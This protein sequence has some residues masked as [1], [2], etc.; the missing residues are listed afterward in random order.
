MNVRSGDRRLPS[1]SI[2]I[3]L[4]TSVMVVISA[5]GSWPAELAQAVIEPPF[6]EN[7]VMLWNFAE[8]SQACLPYEDPLWLCAARQPAPAQHDGEEIQ[9][10]CRPLE[11]VKLSGPEALA[12]IA[13]DWER[14]D[15]LMRPRTP[16]SSVLWNSLWWKHYHKRGLLLADEFL[17][18]AVRATNGQL[19]A[20][21]PLL[22]RF[23]PAIGP[24]R[25]RM[26]QFFGA[27]ASITELRGVVCA[28]DDQ[29]MVLGAL[30]THFRQAYRE[31]DLL[32][33]DGVL[34]GNDGQHHAGVLVGA[35]G[36]LPN[37]V[38]PLP[39]SWAELHSQVTGNFRRNMRKQ[40]ESFEQDGH[41]YRFRAV[42]GSDVAG[43]L[44]TLFALHAQ[45]AQFDGMEVK[46]RD[47]FANRVNRQFLREYT[48]EMARRGSARLYE[49][50]IGGKTVAS[51]LAF[52]MGGDLWLYTSGFDPQWRRY[53]IMTMLTVE[54][55][56]WAIASKYE[57]VNLSCGHDRAKMRWRPAEMAHTY[58]LE[59][60]PSLRGRLAM[61]A[62]ATVAASRRAAVRLRGWRPSRD[63]NR[64][65]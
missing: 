4:L 60:A 62:Y 17:V 31:W 11:V 46:H 39:A 55:M 10:D 61:Q 42:A 44:E 14:L 56:Q 19:V 1:K 5:G 48:L 13:A 34:E 3:L 53:G 7:E 49:L 15:R 45:R 21:A 52:A 59:S 30:E 20:V 24:V 33:W 28:P 37:Y 16:F 26:I 27:D 12:D 51:Q 29:K 65:A 47:R 63:T 23:C 54:V 32:R 6:W 36:R 8:V 35:P 25:W 22:R 43:A 57:R 40:R 58:F 64:Q 50:Q 38:V 41:V 9:R 18:L 2:W